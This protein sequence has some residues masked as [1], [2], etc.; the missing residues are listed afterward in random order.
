M[1]EPN[2]DSLALA[3]QMRRIL[4]GHLLSRALCAVAALG[5][6]DM[7]AEG[8][9]TAENLAERS[10]ASAAALRQVL[11]ALAAFDVFAEHEDGTFSLTPL[12][13]TLRSDAVASA[14]PTAALVGS[15]IGQAWNDFMWTVRTGRSAFGKLYGTDFFS[16]LE[17]K[18]ELRTIFDLSQAEGLR[19]D[20]DEILRRIDFSGSRVVVDVGGGDGAL[21]E[22][23]LAAYPHLR[24]VLIEV[25]QEVAR[26]RQRL[27]AAGLA[28]RFEA[29]AADIF[30]NV[31][32]AGDVYLLRQIMHDWD[33]EHCVALLAAC[34]RAMSEHA[35]LLIIDL[36]VKDNVTS[37]PDSQLAALM[38]LYMM[39]IFDGRER[40]RAQLESLLADA[41]FRLNTVTRLSG[42]MM[43]LRATPMAAR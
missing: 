26:A 39:S 34:R 28:N 1:A 17:L 22:H 31:P 16:Y 33:D 36:V 23:V 20:L 13:E 21:L 7:L 41:G 11:R 4:Y 24:G 29:H 3:V 5:V 42:R 19:L 9:R 37:D 10:S 25:P 18:P 40:T 8:P 35:V 6:P 27:T 15:E 14:V 30:E 38:D 32:A 2:R 12:G 43:A